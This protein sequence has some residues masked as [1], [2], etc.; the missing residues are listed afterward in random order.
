M[1]KT[2]RIVVADDEADIRD[3]FHRI[4]P[5]LGH[6]V[7]ATACDGA[8][9]VQQCMELMPD[10]VITDVKMPNVDGLQA[11]REIQRFRCLPII[12]VSAQYDTD[13]FA[14][15]ANAPMTFL[16]KPIKRRELAQAITQAC[17]SLA[18]TADPVESRRNG[19]K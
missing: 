2:L 6:Q 8:E 11:V 9:L 1:K 12:F 3:Y 5:R 16:A 15:E 7:V 4:L 13:S 14:F 19:A 17:N 10:L 18:K